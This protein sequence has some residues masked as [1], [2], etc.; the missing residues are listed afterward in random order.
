MLCLAV[1]VGDE[2]DMAARFIV[3]RA[4]L[5]VIAASL[6]FLFDDPASLMTA[7]SPTPLRI[8]R[9]YALIAAAL[10]W[11]LAVGIVLFLTA[12]NLPNDR[13]NPFPFARLWTEALA[14]AMIACLLASALGRRNAQPGGK[15]ATLFL[16]V[17]IAVAAIPPPEQPWMTPFDPQYTGMSLGSWWILIAVVSGAFAFVSWDSRGGR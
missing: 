6:P 4:S 15:A 8:R 7:S 9:G 12:R 11:S 10:P 1:G 13:D 5:L 3:A 17:G 16:M 2:F 14:L